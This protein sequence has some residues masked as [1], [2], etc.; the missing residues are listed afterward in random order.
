[1]NTQ[2]SRVCLIA[3]VI[4]CLASL[5]VPAQRSRGRASSQG[6]VAV[7]QSF[8]RYHLP[9]DKNFTGANIKRRRRWLTPELYRLLLAEYHREE[10][11]YEKHP[12]EAVFIEGDPFTNSQEYPDSFR[13]GKPVVHGSQATVPITFYWAN[14]NEPRAAN[15]K[16]KRQ[17]RVWLIHNILPAGDEDLLKLLRGRLQNSKVK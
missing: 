15:V 5:Q 2:R 17:G 16:V 14:G 4:I 11:E 13:V 8:F 10:A 9:E 12:D 6:A 1:M 7:V 3:L